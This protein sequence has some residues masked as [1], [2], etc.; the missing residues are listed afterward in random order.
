MF[1]NNASSHLANKPPISFGPD[2][3][4]ELLHLKT[5]RPMDLA[6]PEK[7]LMFAV[8]AE[9]VE[10]YQKFASSKSRRGLAL[11]RD[12]EEWLCRNETGYLFS[13]QTICELLNFDPIFLRRGLV[14]WMVQRQQRASARKRIQVHYVRGRRRKPI[15]SQ[16]R[17]V[18]SS[19]SDTGR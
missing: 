5:Q 11:F 14:Q 16:I 13:F 19:I 15:R 4:I 7:A 1:T 6:M 18:T 3:L 12:A 9:A 8:L 2:I 10:T 17:K